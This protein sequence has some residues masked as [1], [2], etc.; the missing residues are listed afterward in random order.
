[1]NRPTFAPLVLALLLAAPRLAA[2]SELAPSRRLQAQASV[3]FALPLL[4]SGS[5]LTRA[6]ALRDAGL[7][8]YADAMGQRRSVGDYP[9]N[10]GFALGLAFHVPLR[11]V[12]GLLLGGSVVSTQTGAQP[13]TGGYEE[14]YFFNYLSAG[15][16]AKYYPWAERGWFVQLDGGLG[17][18]FTKNRFKNDADQQRFFHQFGIGQ[19]LG[20]SLGHTL[21]P[22]KNK[23][24]GLELRG[25]YTY[26]STRVE[27]DGLGDDGWGF[28][29]L[30]LSVGLVWLR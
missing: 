28:S 8:Y 23:N 4:H 20:L 26:Y 22:F 5:E 21:L 19:S 1:M 13:S 24:L 27:V 18:V 12:R 6:R 25:A 29:S 2:Q 14:G 16:S 3:G 30:G 10:T 7:S 11:R 17:A 15:F 9:A